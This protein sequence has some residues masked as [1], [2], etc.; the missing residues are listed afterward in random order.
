MKLLFLDDD[1]N[2]IHKVKGELGLLY[3]LTCVTTV[4]ECITALQDQ[5]FDVISLDH[6]LGGKVYVKSGPGTGVEVAEFMIS[7]YY[8]GSPQLVVIHSWNSGGAGNMASRLEDVFV[9]VRAM[10]NTRDYWQAVKRPLTHS[11]ET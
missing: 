1:P 6:D 7:V 4:E 10:F 11:N 9:V 8:C 3:D 2:R 5:E